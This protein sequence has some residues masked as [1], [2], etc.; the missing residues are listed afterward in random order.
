M[1]KRLA[2]VIVLFFAM[3]VFLLPCST[4]KAASAGTLVVPNQYKT[5]QEAVDNASAGDT[6]FVKSGV[7]NL[8]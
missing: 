8:A 6:V 3:S 7:Y 1:N 4:V 2:L 5:I